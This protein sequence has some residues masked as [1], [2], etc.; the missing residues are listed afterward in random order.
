MANIITPRASRSNLLSP[1]CNLC[2]QPAASQPGHLGASCSWLLP[3]HISEASPAARCLV[4][5]NERPLPQLLLLEELPERSQRWELALLDFMR[6]FPCLISSRCSE[7]LL[8]R[9]CSLVS[10]AP[11][12]FRFDKT[13]LGTQAPLCRRDPAASRANAG[14]SCMQNFPLKSPGISIQIGTGNR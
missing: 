3:A 4:G 2:F 13:Y 11:L 7:A 14:R 6:L 12:G 8:T 5:G 1:P 9:S 10:A